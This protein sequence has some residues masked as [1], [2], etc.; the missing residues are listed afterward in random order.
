MEKILFICTGNACRSLMAEAIA[1]H[2]GSEKLQAESAGSQPTGF[3]HPMALASLKKHKIPASGLFSKSWDIFENSPFDI[4]ITVCD[5]AANE[6]C[7]VF[8]GPARRLH[9]GLPDPAGVTGSD[10][11][12]EAAFHATFDRLKNHIEKEL[13]RV[14]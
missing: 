6:P 13:L 14:I 9:W 8:H 11:E 7:P 10:T 3:A 4:V 2:L 5:S 1:N 12:I